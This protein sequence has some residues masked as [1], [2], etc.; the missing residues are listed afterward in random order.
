VIIAKKLLNTIA[1]GKELTGDKAYDVPWFRI[2]LM[3]LGIQPNIPYRAT[4]YEH[5]KLLKPGKPSE[6]PLSY[7]SRW[8]I[9][10][11][12][13]WFSNF[14]RLNIRYERLSSLYRAFWNLAAS[15]ILLQRFLR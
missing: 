6:N 12:F 7:K 2:R 1:K 13:A 11:T 3:Y 8:K 4:W 9:E 5:L 14:K 10:R 15:V